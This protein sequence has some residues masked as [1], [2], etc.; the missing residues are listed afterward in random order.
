MAYKAKTYQTNKQ[1]CN[2]IFISVFDICN[3]FLWAG[4]L[5]LH[6]KHIPA[7]N[8]CCVELF[9]L[10]GTDDFMSMA[11]VGHGAAILKETYFVW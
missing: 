3:E 2:W 5:S 10:L 9:L 11:E 1:I 4:L 7:N 8:G 6:V